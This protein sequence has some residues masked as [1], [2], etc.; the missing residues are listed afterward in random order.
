MLCLCF[1]KAAGIYLALNLAVFVS[2]G[3][4]DSKANQRAKAKH[5]HKCHVDANYATFLKL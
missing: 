4:T 5:A 1:D 2:L 3:V